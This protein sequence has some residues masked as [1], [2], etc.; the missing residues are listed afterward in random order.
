MYAEAYFCTPH[1]EIRHLTP[2]LPKSAVSGRELGSDLPGRGR[3]FARGQHPRRSVMWGLRHPEMAKARPGSKEI[4]IGISL[5]CR[6]KLSERFPLNPG[7][8]SNGT[9]QASSRSACSKS[10]PAHRSGFPERAAAA[11]PLVGRVFSQLRL[12]QKR[13]AWP[14]GK[15]QRGAPDAG[16][17]KANRGVSRPDRCDLAGGSGLRFPVPGARRFVVWGFSRRVHSDASSAKVVGPGSQIIDLHSVPDET[18]F[19]A[20]GNRFVTCIG[21]VSGPEHK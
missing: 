20:A 8:V 17:H 15:R 7:T 1:K 9:P 6:E 14:P 2:R 3:S 16:A 21:S 11:C 13:F 4:P 18:K 19:S 10:L 5:R 12:L